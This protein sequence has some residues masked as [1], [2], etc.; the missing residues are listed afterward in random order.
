M[1]TPADVFAEKAPLLEG[2]EVA[3]I[4]LFDLLDAEVRRE[5]DAVYVYGSFADPDR[6]LDRDGDVS[7]LDVYVTVEDVAVLPT[8][9]GEPAEV[10]TRFGATE[11]EL[12]CRL[13]TQEAFEVFGRS[14]GFDVSLPDAPEAVVESIERAERTAFH[15]SELD[16][17]LL[18]FR[19]LD[20]TLGTPGAFASFVDD[21]PHLQVWPLDE[22]A[23]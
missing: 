11:H 6:E 23:P 3:A 10:S 13:A 17:E 7:D 16:V 15:V 1:S 9:D 21:D 8:A 4:V 12:L 18:R 14:D 22:H 2:L 5:V 19:P 20:L